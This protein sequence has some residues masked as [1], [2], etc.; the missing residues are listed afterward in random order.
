MRFRPALLSLL[1]MTALLASGCGHYQLGTEGK[2]AFTTLYVAP[3]GNATMLPQA[4][5]AVS[6][7]L[8]DVLGRD[9]RVSLVNEPAAADATLTVTLKDYHRDVRAV[10]EDD[11]GLARKFALTLAAECTLHDNRSGRDLFTKR[12]I[13][14]SRDA[15]T[16]GG[17]LQAE[18]QVVPLLADAL[19]QKV[20]HAVLDVW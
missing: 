14:V 18:Y 20:S 6:T 7:Q 13:S 16:D 19:A 9:G 11:T 12:A 3:V 4:Q 10:R 1:A 17:Q 8:R 15:F 5:A 2:L